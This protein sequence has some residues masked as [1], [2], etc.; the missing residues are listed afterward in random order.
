M[1]DTNAHVSDIRTRTDGNPRRWLPVLGVVGLLVGAVQGAAVA[2]STYPGVLAE[3][4]SPRYLR[5][6]LAVL[7]PFLLLAVGYLWATDV[8]VESEYRPALGAV[9]ASYLLGFG[10]A[11]LPR[12][13]FPEQ[14]AYGWPLG[15]VGFGLVELL[16]IL[17][18]PFVFVG[19]AS[20]AYVQ[21]RTGEA[22]AG[23][24]DRD[25]GATISPT[26]AVAFGV[27]GLLAGLARGHISGFGLAVLL[28]LRLDLALTNLLVLTGLPLHFF[29]NW[30]L[31]FGL[32]YV[33]SREGNPASEWPTVFAVVVPTAVAGF[34]LLFLGPILVTWPELRFLVQPAQLLHAVIRTFGFVTVACVVLAGAMVGEFGA[35]S[36]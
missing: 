15:M 16:P 11:V 28:D 10:L 32:G 35:D 29:A 8:P 21:S 23:P 33:W 7:N 18:V 12:F 9:T 22:V 4:F 34:V 5:L 20:V 31:P 19:G 2:V 36:R 1:T 13:L 26:W 6:L 24:S 25:A 27:V 30:L 14:A 3:A 17:A